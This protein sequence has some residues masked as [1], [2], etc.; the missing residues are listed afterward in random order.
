MFLLSTASLRGY[1]L[2]RICEF[3]KASHYDGIDL[4]ME[5]NLYD[6]WSTSYIT[7]VS[8]LT[9]MPIVSITAPERKMTRELVKKVMKLT[10]SLGVKLVNFYPPHRVDPYKDWF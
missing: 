8:T 9:Q 4:S 3:A 7:E 6:T 1:S 2:H 5:M 10:D